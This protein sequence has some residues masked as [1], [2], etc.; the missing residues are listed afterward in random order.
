MNHANHATSSGALRVTDPGRRH[1]ATTGVGGHRASRSVSAT[2]TAS[3]AAP[4]RHLVHTVASGTRKYDLYVP[5]GFTGDEPV[6]LIVMLHGGSQNARDFAAGTRMNDLA[7][8]DGF[9][10]AYPEQTSAGNSGGFWNWFRPEHQGRDAGEPA[11]IAAITRE[12]MDD[13]AVDPARVYV[14]GLSAGGAMAAVMAATYP[15]LYA[16]VGVHSG[17]AY[18]AA[19]DVGSAFSAMQSGGSPAIAGDIPVI[20]FHGDADH[21]VRHVN[22]DQLVRTVLA[23][24]GSAV[25]PPLT[26]Q[27]TENGRAYRRTVYPGAGGRS[28]AEQWTVHGGGHAWYGGS[29][30]GSY[31]DPTG[32]D[33]SAE[34]VRFFHE[35]PARRIV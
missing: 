26:T 31:T 34:M 4:V 17:V 5:S 28:I 11:I 18:R 30:V 6:P 35:H 13:L 16:A 25:G 29:S 1:L 2:A 20:V 24:T 3:A 32:P 9:L 8:R 22:S 12:I 7:E 21:T 15:D 27:D 14:A 23:S 33:A 19:H 10:V